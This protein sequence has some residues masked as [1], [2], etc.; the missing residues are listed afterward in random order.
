MGKWS[1]FGDGGWTLN[2]GAGNRN[3]GFGGLALTR[4]VMRRL[5]IGGE[6][7]HQTVDAI[8]TRNN[9]GLGL[10]ASW[11]LTEEWSLVGSGGPLVENR[12]TVARYAAHIALK[13]HN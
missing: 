2:P 11:A 8:D 10:G 6:V 1:L 3:Y 5:C 4:S 7:Y 13:F 12:S 9:T